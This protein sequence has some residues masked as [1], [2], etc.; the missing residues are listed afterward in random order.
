M[1]T[2]TDLGFGYAGF[3]L[4]HFG[5]GTPAAINSSTKALFKK[6]DGTYGNCGL[7]DPLTG[8]DVLDDSGNPI[9]DNS[10]NQMVYLALRTTRNS[11]VLLNFGI[12][13]KN[14][15]T[16]TD[17]IKLKFQLAVNDAVKHLTDRKLITITLV[18]VT[19]IMNKPGAI[20]VL[21]N[22]KDNSNGEINSFKLLG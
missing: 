18:E 22:W 2:L 1:T 17:N 10:I 15:K 12:D 16:I 5:Y 14:I 4:S 3:G 6:L 20:Q 21:V 19:E 13:I 7:I 8:D 9:G 11:S